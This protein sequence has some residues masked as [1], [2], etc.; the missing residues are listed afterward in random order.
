M[1]VTIQSLSTYVPFA[2]KGLTVL[3]SIVDRTDNQGEFCRNCDNGFYVNDCT[4]YHAGTTVD[5]CVHCAPTVALILGSMDTDEIVR[6]ELNRKGFHATH[7]VAEELGY[8]D[9]RSYNP[10]ERRQVYINR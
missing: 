2:V 4:V 5:C 9:D 6:V 3:T 7:M 10:A 1:D 8:G